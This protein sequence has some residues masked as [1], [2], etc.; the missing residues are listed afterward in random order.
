MTP[1]VEKIVVAHLLADETLTDLIGENRVS[2]ELPPNAQLP[3][4]RIT[5]SGGRVVIRTWLYAVRLTVEAWAESKDAAWNALTTAVA[6]LEQN[7]DG[8]LVEG[9]VI[10]ALDQEGGI[11]WSPDTETRTPRYLTSIVVTIH[12]ETQ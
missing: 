5:L 10:S 1:N 7:L 8:A 9:G 12:P 2:T 6:S 4:I 11:L 3:R